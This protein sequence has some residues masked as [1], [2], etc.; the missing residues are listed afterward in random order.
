MAT[1]LILSFKPAYSYVFFNDNQYYG[2]ILAAGAVLTLAGIL[3]CVGALS[4]SSCLLYTVIIN[5]HHS[6]WLRNYY[7]FPFSVFTVRSAVHRRRSSCRLPFIQEQ[8][9]ILGKASG[10]HQTE[11]RI[12]LRRQCNNHTSNRLYSGR[13]KWQ[14][15][16]SLRHSFTSRCCAFSGTVAESIPTRAGQS[17]STADRPTRTLPTKVGL[18]LFQNRAASIKSRKNAKTFKEEASEGAM[19]PPTCTNK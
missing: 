1:S 13:S 2:V 14:V 19:T 3:G 10:R 8:P 7:T 17:R 16:Q 9:D 11:R 6:L 15:F 12:W 4:R 18:T 5:N